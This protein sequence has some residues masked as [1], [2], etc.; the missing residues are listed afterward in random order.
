[1]TAAQWT[2]VDTL[3]KDGLRDENTLQSLVVDE[4]GTLCA[5]WTHEEQGICR[6]VCTTTDWRRERFRSGGRC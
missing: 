3:T 4:G 6:A 1:M 2:L 5:V